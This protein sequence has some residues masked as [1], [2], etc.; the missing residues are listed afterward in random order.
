MYD[1]KPV[2]RHKLC[3]CTNISCMLCGSDRIMAH[4]QKRLGIRPGETTADGRFT[5]KAVECLGAC[6]GAPVM[7]VGR[8][9][10]EQLTPAKLDEILDELK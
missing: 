10:Y 9:Y 7:M 5:L 6:G 3:V 1:L 8:K 4:L 2:G